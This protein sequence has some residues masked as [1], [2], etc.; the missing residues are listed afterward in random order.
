M[1]LVTGATGTVGGEVARLLAAAHPLRILARRP[2]RVTVT[3]PAVEVAGGEYADR[4]SLDRAL[5]GV[6]AA[7][8]VTGSIGE[9]D[10][11]R[12]VEAARAAGVR[13][14]VKL[15]ALAVTD[16]AADDLITRRQRENET[17]VR[18]SGL[19]WALLRPRAFMTNTLSWARSVREEG[20]VRALHGDAPNATV[21]P[22]DI[23]EVAARV[24][25]EPGAHE[26]RAYALSG[27]AAVTAAE[28]TALLGDALGRPLRFEELGPERAR[29]ALLA[30]YPQPVAEALLHSAERQRA[31]AKAGV[32]QT[33]QE[34]TGRPARSY[35]EWARD[36][37]DAFA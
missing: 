5:K 17:A 12:F 3:G 24:L 29:A 13:H 34:L 18:E 11:L 9:P 23:A 1:I 36:H 37:A 6:R 14:L 30:R 32:A 27:P 35:A 7:F 25:T 15:S 16:P 8:L 20:V 21:D 28:Q 22:R 2:E 31:G 4:D 33:V 10:D 19:A 26:G